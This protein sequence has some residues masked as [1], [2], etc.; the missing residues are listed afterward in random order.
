VKGFVC[1]QYSKVYST[2]VYS[3]PA[4]YGAQCTAYLH[5]EFGL[6]AAAGLD[7][8]PPPPPRWLMMAS[9]SSMKMVEGA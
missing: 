1:W 7:A 3:V 6:E 2:P 4:V 5:Q 8:S 9:I